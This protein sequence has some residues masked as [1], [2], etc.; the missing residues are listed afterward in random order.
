MVMSLVEQ[1]H[2]DDLGV[3]ET[4]AEALVETGRYEPSLVLSSCGNF[5]AGNGKVRAEAPRSGKFGPKFQLISHL[6]V[7]LDA[8]DTSRCSPSCHA[9]NFGYEA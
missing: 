3:R 1:A 2:D 4:V 5:M 9:Q 8:Q 6:L 7:R